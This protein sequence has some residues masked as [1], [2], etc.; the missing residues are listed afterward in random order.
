[1]SVV[2]FLAVLGAS[3]AA[4]VVRVLS[5]PSIPGTSLHD[6][7]LRNMFDAPAGVTQETNQLLVSVS[8]LPH[9]QQWYIECNE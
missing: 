8:H 9:G 4:G 3:T 6:T 2:N 1:M 5:F 7:H